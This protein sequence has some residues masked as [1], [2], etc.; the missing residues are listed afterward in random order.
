[1]YYQISKL[2]HLLNLPEDIILHILHLAGY[3]RLR[4]GVYMNQI[5]RNFLI[6]KKLEG[7]PRFINWVVRL[8]VKTAWFRK[9][10]C[11]KMIIIGNI[12]YRDSTGMTTGRQY[13][14]SWFEYDYEGEMH[15]I[16]SE[17]NL[18]V[19]QNKNVVAF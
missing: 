4:N 17:E 14:V 5:N 18:L 8:P 12:Q 11:D 19:L 10:F 1:M 9:S 15:N 6:Y 16:A 3:I 13:K 7:V 2:V